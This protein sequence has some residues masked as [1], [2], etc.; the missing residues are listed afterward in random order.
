MKAFVLAG[1]EGTR[2][3]P[4]TYTVPKPMLMLGGKPIIRYV[5]ENLMRD[6]AI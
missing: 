3:R 2:L 6:E 5:I 1:G 4:Y